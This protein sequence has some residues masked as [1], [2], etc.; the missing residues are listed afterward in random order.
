MHLKPVYLVA[1]KPKPPSVPTRRAFMIAGATFLAG[2]GLGG[3]CGYAAGTSAVEGN[4]DAPS[5]P[6]SSGDAVLD[7]L[8]RLAVDA[9]VSELNEKWLY[10]SDVYSLSYRKDEHLPRGVE[11]LIELVFSNPNLE[12]RTQLA[13][14]LA[15]FVE[16]GDPVLRDRLG[17]HVRELRMIR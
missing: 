7:D 14:G 8:R 16:L 10:F 15:Q 3:A 4:G 1:P 17:H 11:R 6:K 13:Q 5:R 9:P 12:L 2:A